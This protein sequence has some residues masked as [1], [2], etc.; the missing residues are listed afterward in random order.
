MLD[1]DTVDRLARAPERN[2]PLLNVALAEEGTATALLSLASSPALGPE[3]L[4]VIGER[5]AREGE[6][7]GRDPEACGEA[8][9]AVDL[10][11]LLVAHPNA[12]DDL[13][14]AAL[15]RHADEAFFVLAAACHPR[16]TTRAVERAIDWPAATAA[17]DRP[18]LALLSAPAI[19]EDTIRLWSN[20]SSALRR[21]ASALLATDASAIATLARDPARRVRRAAAANAFAG[22]ARTWI[23][24]D[25]APD[26]R[27]SRTT[28]TSTPRCCSTIS[29]AA[30]SRR[31][32]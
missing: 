19:T 28:R 31:R 14:D 23:A 27:G 5:V 2:A 21:E 3:A 6:A 8:S 26:V 13:R 12:P 17:H 32:A 18:W 4:G 7:V 16:A 25:P 20:D 9:I 11:R 24:E 29:R 1:R 10:D 22:E 15:G 30:R